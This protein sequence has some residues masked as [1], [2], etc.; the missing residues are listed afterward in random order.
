MRTYGRVYKPDVTYVWTE[1]QT[2][3]SGAN[4]NVWLTTLIQSLLLNLGESP[5]YANYGIPARPSVMQQIFPDFYVYRTQQ[6]FAPY[7][8]ALLVA[9]E[10]DPDPTYQINVT[11]NN[12]VKVEASVPI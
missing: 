11:L 7:F 4:D 8:A 1:I 6:Q 2:D 12:G 5:F 10:I 9:K 3:A